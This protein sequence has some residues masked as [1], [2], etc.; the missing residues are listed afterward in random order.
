[1]PQTFTQPGRFKIA[2][3]LKEERLRDCVKVI[4]DN[5]EPDDASPALP[6][7]TPEPLR[8]YVEFNEGGELHTESLDEVLSLANSGTRRIKVVAINTH[9]SV[10]PQVSLRFS[11]STFATVGYNISGSD[12]DVFFLAS[13]LDEAIA[14]TR[15]WY[16]RI[17]RADV[18]RL[19]FTV[20]LVA[21]FALL[22]WLG[23][24]AI[25]GQLSNEPVS[26]R[27]SALGNLI[28]WG[29]F[30]IVL[31]VGYPLNRLRSWLF[32]VGIFA[33]GEGKERLQRLQFWRRTL[34]VGVVL[35]A[36][37]NVVTGILLR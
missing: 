35:A 18:V 34:G 14:R 27:S 31:V 23:V 20:L 26:A 1:M 12:Q 17:A 11:D 15:E 36:V 30:L 5:V 28:A 6:S 8:F 29:A 13:K 4:T 7:L 32:P 10:R 2:F 37:L 22:L 24:L 3:V 19:G 21:F 9:W 33:I 16:S 25:T